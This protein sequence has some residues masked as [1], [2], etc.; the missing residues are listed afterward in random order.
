MEY[1]DL[2]RFLHWN[3]DFHCAHHCVETYTRNKGQ[4][5]RSVLLFIP[6]F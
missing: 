3:P 5:C 1:I 4:C 2:Y 6:M